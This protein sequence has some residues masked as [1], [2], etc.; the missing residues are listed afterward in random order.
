MSGGALA[1]QW[2]TTITMAGPTF[3]FSTLARTAS[4]ITITTA[5]FTDVAEKAGVTVGGWSTGATW[6]DYA[7]DGLLDLFV[8]GYVKFDP[9]NPPIAGKGGLPRGFCMRPQGL[10]VDFCAKLNHAKTS[11][12]CAVSV[13]VS[14]PI[15][16]LRDR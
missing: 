12:T 6:G 7:H 11:R 2:A 10:E 15:R 16:V 8:P 1:S 3:T 9:D 5:R 14:S 13:G 4:T